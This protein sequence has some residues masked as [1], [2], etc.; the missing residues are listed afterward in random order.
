MCT[1]R[2]AFVALIFC[3][4]PVLA[5]TPSAPAGHTAVTIDPHDFDRYAGYY[6]LG[7][8]LVVRLWREG[9]HFYFGTVGTPQRLELFAESSTQFFLK[10][11]PVVFSFHPAAGGTVTAMTMNQAG[12]DIQA[13]RI[14][15][16]QAKSIPS[17]PHGHPMPRTWPVVLLKPQMLT[18]PTAGIMDVWPSF[19]PDG[20]TVLFSRTTDRGK[21]WTLY[22]VSASGGT[23]TPF[24]ALPGSVTRVDWSAPTGRLAFNRNGPGGSHGI[25]VSDADGG[26]AHTVATGNATFPAYAF[27]YPDG[28]SIGFV[29]AARGILYRVNAAGGAPIALTRQAQVLA[30]MSRVAPDGKWVAFAGQKNNG[31]AYDQEE[32]QI[33]LTDG[34]GNARPLETPPLPGRAP[35]WSPDGRRIVFESDRGSPDGRYAIF[36]INR[37]GTGLTQLT[38]Y[39]LNAGHPVFSPDGRRLVF[40]MGNPAKNISAIGIVELPAMP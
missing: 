8:R 23:A 35:S 2:W 18:N 33:W 16:A 34:S 24:A 3:C 27:W 11:L 21:N 25:W 37:D 9:N 39:A 29:D 12:R 17:A 10:N 13:V 5:Q 38:D 1:I 14:D 26:H 20:G 28:K 31:Q 4:V 40:D 15:E 36:L 30:G 22:C 32:N 7:P 6:R 19:S